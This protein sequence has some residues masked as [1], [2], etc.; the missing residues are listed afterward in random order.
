[1]FLMEMSLTLDA[2]ASVLKN[3]SRIGWRYS[4]VSGQFEH[5]TTFRLSSCTVRPVVALFEKRMVA[6]FKLGN[7]LKLS[8]ASR[9][10]LLK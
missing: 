2:A 1:M 4:V 10:S 3:W 6:L 7:L 5:W 8:K 9:Y